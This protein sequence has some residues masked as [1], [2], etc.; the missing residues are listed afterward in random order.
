MKKK[1]IF[2]VL[3]T[4]VAVLCFFAACKNTEEQPQIPVASATPF[5]IFEDAQAFKQSLISNG[6]V[7]C[8]I[9]YSAEAGEDM[10][11]LVELLQSMLKE[12][13]GVMIPAKTD[14]EETN[15]NEIEI[16]LGNTNRVESTAAS[17]Y[18]KFGAWVSRAKDNKIV[19]F[20][21][22]KET[23]KNAIKYFVEKNLMLTEENGAK[24]VVYNS[25]YVYADNRTLF[26]DSANPMKN[27]VIVY[28]EKDS[29]FELIAKKLQQR[30]KDFTGEE[31]SVIAESDSVGENSAEL[32]EKEII[33]GPVDRENIKELCKGLKKEEYIVTTIDKNKVIMSADDPVVLEECIDNETETFNDIS[34][35]RRW[36]FDAKTKKVVYKSEYNVPKTE[37]ADLRIMS[38][39]IL[40]EFWNS[41]IPVEM[42][43]DGLASLVNAYKPDVIGMQEVSE[44]WFRAIKSEFDD[45]SYKFVTEK[46]CYDRAA[47]VTILYNSETVK[48]LAFECTPFSNDKTA[49]NTIITW[50]AFER[51]SD[52]KKFIVVSSHWANNQLPQHVP[53]HLADTVSTVKKL[54]K[55][56]P[57][58]PVFVTGDY[59][60]NEKTEAYIEFAEKIGYQDPKFTAKQILTQT[61]TNAS[62]YK[63]L[64]QDAGDAIDHIFVTPTTEIEMYNIISDKTARYS[65][66]HSPVYIDLKL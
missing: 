53:V 46:T 48:P 15:T 3:L 12:K 35:T 60:K 39:N 18:F 57:G 32:Y 20:G 7:N 41:K 2:F 65:S 40:T 21:H 30:I 5:R 6:E 8:S 26:F 61:K 9:V 4:F 23:T 10:L 59:N 49:L 63:D 52:G 31:M 51:L 16:L 33:I 11:E 43:Q 19:I 56:Y 17:E 64:P 62:I 34:F 55:E 44:N 28:S 42:R 36:M 47:L 50:A 13:T 45:G 27:F 54:E 38:W 29:Q 24:K 14:A 25:D 66:D 37:G 58:I 22:Y 1:N